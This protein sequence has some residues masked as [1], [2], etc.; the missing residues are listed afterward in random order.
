M[1]HTH[2]FN[3]S[4]NKIHMYIQDNVTNVSSHWHDHYELTL[5]LGGEAWSTVNN[6]RSFFKKGDLIFMT[7]SDFHGFEII[8]PLQLIVITFHISGLPY[9]GLTEI[10]YSINCN[11]ITLKE[12][13]FNDIQFFIYKLQ[14]ELDSE[15]KYSYYYAENIFSCILIEL[16][17]HNDEQPNSNTTKIKK[18]LH[19][20]NSHFKE[21]ITLKD[22]ADY[23]EVSYSN[24]GKYIKT[25]LGETFPEYLNKVRLEYSCQLLLNSSEPI[26]DIAN[27]SGFSSSSY[28]SKIFKS[29]YGI[30]PQEYRKRCE[31]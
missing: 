20:I 13:E 8:S 3:E 24:I 21:E 15:R 29:K 17:R 23:A 7:P 16:F 5:C 2:R 26:S 27:F 19:Y 25:H 12:K 6:E 14:E 4:N 31:E 11:T 9:T 28:F 30:T 18:I 22:V 1:K 10:L